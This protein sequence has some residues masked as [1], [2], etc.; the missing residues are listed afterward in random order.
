MFSFFQSD[1]NQ[2]TDRQSDIN[3]QIL[4]V[5]AIAFTASLFNSL[6]GQ[7]LSPKK[8]ATD[9]IDCTYTG[10]DWHWGYEGVYGPA[11]WGKHE[12]ACNG[13]KQ[14]PIDIPAK[15]GG[16]FPKAEQTPLKMSNYGHVRFSSFSNSMERYPGDDE[17]VTTG[18]LMNNGHTAVS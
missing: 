13:L 8:V 3:D 10:S 12:P 17:R 1:A 9:T 11:C 5:A 6:I 2:N 18:D 15:Y 7:I 14:S 4:P 16:L